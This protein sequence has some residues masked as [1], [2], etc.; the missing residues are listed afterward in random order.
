[1]AD[2]LQS[3]RV[4]F[5]GKGQVE[6]R[7]E[8][9][10]EPGP[11]QVL[12][13]AG[14]SLIST[15]TEC[16]I[17]Q[18]LYEAGSHWDNWVRFP[19]QAGYSMVGRVVA[20]GDGVKGV[21]PGRRLAVRAGHAQ[22]FLTSR[23]VATVPDGLPDT[24]AAWF[25]LA[26]IVQNG[27]RRAQIVLGETVVIIGLGILGQLACQYA[28]VCGA[29]RVIAVDPAADRLRT[30]QRCGATHGLAMPVAEAVDAVRTIT[31]GALADV[32]FDVTGHAAV[33]S[34]ALGMVRRL[35][36]LMLL[37][38]TGTPSQQHLT[39]D[40]ITRGI[41]II[42]THDG[43]PPAEGND[44]Y[45]WSH[46]RMAEVFFDLLA[47][48]RLNVRDITSHV[49]SPLDAPQV[50]RGLVERRGEHLGVV[51]DWSRV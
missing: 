29:R 41:S 51:F 32:V 43:N 1:M 39:A 34:A 35:G 47:Q 23:W 20:V 9:I 18:Q 5:A 7:Q 11:G 38:D 2:G 44:W 3:K 42:G 4:V 8:G 49:V 6:V 16:I 13:E 27:I 48:G 28:K 17:L 12:V 45:P 15:G 33:F 22:R 25:A 30:A 46:A 24:E 19:F 26:C 21:E 14:A 50:Y 36:R 40:V 10:G 31:G 37:G